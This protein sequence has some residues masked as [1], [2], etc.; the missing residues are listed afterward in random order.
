MLVEHTTRFT[1]YDYVRLSMVS[2][3]WRDLSG[4]GMRHLRALYYQEENGGLEV[5]LGTSD[6]QSL[7]GRMWQQWDTVQAR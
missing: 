4:K 6:L 1:Y 2:T 3:N 7:R 5:V